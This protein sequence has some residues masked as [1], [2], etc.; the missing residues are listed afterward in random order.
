MRSVRYTKLK[1]VL[2]YWTKKFVSQNISD[3]HSSAEYIIAHALGRK[4]LFRVR[5]DTVLSEAQAKEIMTL[6]KMRLTRMPVQYILGEWDFQDVTLKMK[7]PVLIP[8][9]ETEE[10]TELCSTSLG[11]LLTREGDAFLEIGPGSGAI[12]VSLLKQFP[13]LQAVAVDIS[14][15]ACQLTKTNAELTG[16]SDRL[17]L[18]HGDL[19]AEDVFENLLK[20][21]PFCLAVSNP[22]YITTAEMDK[23]QEE[24]KCFED[25]RALHG[26]EDGLDLVRGVLMRC[27]QLLQPQ[28]HLWLEVGESQPPLVEKFT[29]D[30]NRWRGL[31]KRLIYQKTVTDI[32]GKPRF[33]HL[34]STCQRE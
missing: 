28:G 19:M 25:H 27:S 5:P 3:P 13:E 20:F 10:L 7:P 11:S 2:Q 30:S 23:L 17:T 12:T 29:S 32:N 9:P 15:D 26:G 22:P 31:S 33:C 8:R 1:H 14:E 16:T 18:I 34:I 21:R 6:C 4:T 24:I